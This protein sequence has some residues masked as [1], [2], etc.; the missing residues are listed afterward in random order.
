VPRAPL[1]DVPPEFQFK[2][3]QAGQNAALGDVEDT[4]K[5]PRHWFPPGS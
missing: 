5:K 2:F 1:R 3:G 4:T